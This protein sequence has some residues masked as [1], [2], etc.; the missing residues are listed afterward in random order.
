M[1]IDCKHHYVRD[2]EHVRHR[3]CQLCGDV[4]REGDDGVWHSLPGA[5]QV[6]APPYHP[7]KAIQAEREHRGWSRETLAQRAG[8][9][10]QTLVRLENGSPG[11]SVGNL[12]A[13]LYALDMNLEVHAPASPAERLP[14]HPL[15]LDSD[16][17][18]CVLRAAV[19]AACNKLDELFPGAKPEVNGICSNFA[20]L[21]EE[22]LRAMLEGNPQARRT[23]LTALPV[24]GYSER[25]FGS[26]RVLPRDADGWLVRVKDRNLFLEPSNRYVGLASAYRRL[27]GITDLYSSWDAAVRCALCAIEDQGH[28]EGALEIVPGRWAGDTHVTLWQAPED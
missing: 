2:A 4:Q 7:G 8:V 26:S 24:L 1:A 3:A 13:V 6:A 11:T 5:E 17:V 25:T 16:Q 23:S 15:N 10:L 19:S 28:P 14:L 22:H 12:T 27:T 18:G 20:G 21:L 9:G